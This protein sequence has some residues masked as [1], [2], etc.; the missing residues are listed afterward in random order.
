[1]EKEVGFGAPTLKKACPR[2]STSFFLGV[3]YVAS[4]CAWA[5][6]ATP[7][8]KQLWPALGRC[9]H[10]LLTKT[11]T[12]T[13][14]RLPLLPLRLED[15]LKV[16][17]CTGLWQR[18]TPRRELWK[19]WP[20]S[21]SRCVFLQW[22]GKYKHNVT[23]E[24]LPSFPWHWT[25]FVVCPRVF[26]E[27]P[28]FQSVAYPRFLEKAHQRLSSSPDSHAASALL[29]AL[30][31]LRHLNKWPRTPAPVRM[32]KWIC[33]YNAHI[34]TWSLCQESTLH[35]FFHHA[36]MFESF[37]QV[38]HPIWQCLIDPGRHF[39]FHLRF[40]QPL[41]TASLFSNV[42]WVF[43]VSLFCL[44]N[45]SVFLLYVSQLLYCRCFLCYSILILVSFP[46]NRK[47]FGLVSW[48]VWTGPG[49]YTWRSEILYLV[50]IN[51]LWNHVSASPKHS[52]PKEGA[53]FVDPCFHQN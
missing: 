45:L 20:Q 3:L 7:E 27:Q 6:C 51:L 41:V 30:E 48:S 10:D 22:R 44:F 14:A 49:S 4:T 53:L 33:L 8:W 2:A 50:L 32:M 47:G 38:N 52:K 21:L 13:L 19:T 36:C 46:A 37:S 28:A 1:M 12:N 23:T 18:Q 26:E 24:I 16:Q 34:F 29:I 31:G 42:I 11:P 15:E 40:F 17:A 43:L 39:G 25:K 9:M 35:W 5:L